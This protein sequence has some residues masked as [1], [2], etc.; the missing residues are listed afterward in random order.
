[1]KSILTVSL[2][3]TILLLANCH[4]SNDTVTHINC[5]GLVTDTLGTGDNAK[6]YMPN[7]FT[8]NGDGRNDII[9]P[10]LQNITAFTFTIY[11]GNNNIVFT[12]STPLQ[13]WTTTVTANSFETYYYKIQ[14]TTNNS[15]KIGMCGELYKLSC[16]PSSS[17]TL[18]FEDQLTTG[19]FT[20]TTGEILP[21]C[22]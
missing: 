12:S 2:L 7:A 3:S 6:I 20:G 19:G 11:D 13:G 1:M 8:P 22:P 9:R 16:R 18:Y 5:N 17:P 14:A 21:T 10:I 4:K 15:H